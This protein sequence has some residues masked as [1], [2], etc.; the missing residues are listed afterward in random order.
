MGEESTGYWQSHYGKRTAVQ[1]LGQAGLAAAIYTAYAGLETPST[2]NHP[3]LA[4]FLV[5]ANL[6]V[7]ALTYLAE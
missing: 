1:I 6:A 2:W 7:F 4:V 5:G 3:F